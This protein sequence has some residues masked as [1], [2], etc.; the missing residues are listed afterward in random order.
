MGQGIQLG[1]Q[2][3]M[4]KVPE[5]QRQYFE[6]RGNGLAKCLPCSW[7][8]KQDVLVSLHR[9]DAVDSHLGTRSRPPSKKDKAKQQ[10]QQQEEEE[11]EQ[12]VEQQ[13]EE[14]QQ[15]Q[16]PVLVLDSDDD[17]LV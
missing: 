14:Q 6:D 3:D 8:K 16:Q 5:L 7:V 10:Q 9:T 1:K 13:Q 4:N 12:E 11:Q 15:Q 17:E 2:G